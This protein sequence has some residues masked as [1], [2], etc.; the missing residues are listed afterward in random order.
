MWGSIELRSSLLSQLPNVPLHCQFRVACFHVFVCRRCPIGGEVSRQQTQIPDLKVSFILCPFASSAFE[1]D[2]VRTSAYD[3][4]RDEGAL[5]KIF[6]S[7]VDKCITAP[8]Q[9]RHVAVIRTPW[10]PVLAQVLL[11][12]TQGLTAGSTV[13]NTLW[14][15]KCRLYF[16]TIHHCTLRRLIRFGLQLSSTIRTHVLNTESLFSSHM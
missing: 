3:W 8:S 11:H 1:N 15:V 6:S 9:Y 5:A 2:S 12:T 16:C 13:F 4:A 10:S 14:I 7:E